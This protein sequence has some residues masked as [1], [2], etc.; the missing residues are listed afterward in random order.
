MFFN[1]SPLFNSPLHL[2]LLSS[3]LLHRDK[4]SLSS[5]RPLRS[6]PVLHKK[7]AALAFVSAPNNLPLNPRGLFPLPCRS[8]AEALKVAPC[9]PSPPVPSPPVDKWESLKLVNI[10]VVARN[11]VVKIEIIFPQRT[12]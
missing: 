10:F 11:L 3:F 6:V 5:H 8:Y 4:A 2:L 7:A 12:R 1:T 9:V